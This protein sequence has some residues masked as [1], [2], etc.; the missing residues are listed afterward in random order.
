MVKHLREISK[1][2]TSE[3][4]LTIGSFDGVHIGH[5]EIIRRL[6]AGAHAQGA[7]AVVVTFHPHPMVVLRS[8]ADAFYLTTPD[9]RAEILGE[10]GIDIVLTHEFNKDVS[11][12]S[13][14]DFILLLK[15]HFG[16]RQ[17]WIGHDFALGH[18]REGNV[19]RLRELGKEL[20]YVVNVV[21]PL[22]D[23]DQV[24]SSSRIRNHI[25]DGDVAA[26]NKLLGRPY[27]LEG[28]VIEGDGRG[29]TI[30]IPT[31]NLDTGNE[32]LIPGNGVYACV[33]VFDGKQ[34]PAAT[35]IGYRPTF[36]GKRTQAWVE[37]HILD[38]TGDLYG[39]QVKLQFLSRLRGEQKF[40]SVQDL[41]QQINRDIQ[42]T[43]KIAEEY[44]IQN[45]AN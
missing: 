13:A 15:S 33:A 38:F 37:T 40:N 30:G 39:R 4:W 3:A 31:A 19:E 18:D 17:L 45:P 10:L 29:K 22:T 42:E 11:A 34:L 32:K 28:K 44:L 27:L 36:D 41:V 26:A 2:Y 12:L 35:N 24:V 7:P 5:Q 20:D 43:R 25:R 9:E 6:T 8:R 23:G 14:R 21:D 16:M 1:F